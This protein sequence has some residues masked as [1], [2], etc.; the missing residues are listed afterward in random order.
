MIHDPEIQ[1]LLKEYAHVFKEK[2]T[3]LPPNRTIKYLINIFKAMPKSLALYRL[4]PM[5]NNTLKGFID[6][7]LENGFIQP[8]ESPCGAVVFFVK[9]K[10]GGL[11]LV[12]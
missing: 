3:I 8:S 11:R 1:S 9:N 12:T 5:E 2:L 4:C 6:K 10:E 7:K